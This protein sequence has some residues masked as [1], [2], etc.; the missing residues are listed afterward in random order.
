MKYYILLFSF[1]I[2]GCMNKQSFIKPLMID[3]HTFY[4]GFSDNT[5][6]VYVSPKIDVLEFVNTY[7]NKFGTGEE[8]S[9]HLRLEFERNLNLTFGE[10]HQLEIVDP[11]HELEFYNNEDFYDELK[12]IVNYNDIEYLIFNFFKKYKNTQFY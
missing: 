1:L 3:N 10:N 2:V 11:L 4:R 5:F 12:S 8:F 9:N 6:Y 7:D